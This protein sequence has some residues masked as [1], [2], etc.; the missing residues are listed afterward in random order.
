LKFKLI[1]TISNIALFLFLAALGLIPYFVMGYSFSVSFWKMNWPLI[2]GWVIL[3][4]VLNIFFLANRKLFSLL[5]KEDWP[6]LIDYLEDKVIQKGNYS[7][8]LVRLLAN[9]YLV[10]SDSASVMSLENK[11]AINKPLLLDSNALVFGTARILGNDTAGALHFFK[12]RKDSAKAEPKDWVAW[13]YGFSLLLNRQ[14]EDAV[15]EFSLLASSSR[16][17]VVTALS[18]YFLDKNLYIIMPQLRH[19]FRE[20]SELG[21]KRALNAMPKKEAWKREI[22]KLSTEI[23][24]AAIAS[25]LDDTR[26]WLY[27]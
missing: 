17:G 22:D 8:R 20:I 11:V 10:L 23:Y 7:S 18:S 16:D 15:K 6:A 4:F 5:E 9:C 21:K 1:F 26:I 2:L 3:I 25:F 14:I 24:A 12:T 13:Y 27:S 19:E